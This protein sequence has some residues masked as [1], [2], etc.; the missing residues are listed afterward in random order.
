MNDHPLL[1][2]A[3]VVVTGVGAQWLAWRL[4]LP[5]LLLLLAAG[6]L[7]GPISGWMLEEPLLDPDAVLGDLLLPFVTLSVALILYEGGLTLR[8]AELKGAGAPTWRLV[9]MGMAVTWVLTAVA[10]HWLLN[11]AW[12]LAILFGAILVVT[13]PT[14]IIPLL[15]E[16]RPKGRVG[17]IAKWEGIIIDPIGA[18][19][20]VLVFEV[21]L[22]GDLNEAPL[23]VVL[24]IAKTVLLAGGLGVVAGFVLAALLRAF[25]I[26]EFLENPVSL[27]FVIAVSTGS[28]FIQSESG[29]FAATAMG[30]TLANQRLANV[31]SLVEFKENLRVL[32]ISSLFI[33][34]AARVPME[35]I[36]QIG[37]WTVPFLLLLIAAI[38]PVCVF[39]STVGSR[40]ARAERIFLMCLSPRGIVAAAV[41]S[42]FALRMQDEGF[43]QS[44][45]L[46]PITFSVIVGTVLFSSIIV[47]IIARRMGVADPNPQGVL[48]AGAHETARVLAQAINDHGY[49]VLLVDTNRQNIARA[50]MAGLET[51]VGSII[52]ERITDQLD[53]GGLGYLFAI[54]PNDWVN[55]LAVRRFARIF[56][57]GNV[58]QAAPTRHSKSASESHEHLQGRW[59]FGKDATVAALAA[60]IRHG[61]TIKATPITE[62]FGL[63][64]LHE[65]YSG[66]ALPLF[67]LHENK[68]LQV[69]DDEH[70]LNVRPGQT[71]I[72][73]VRPPE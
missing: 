9:T 72:S 42:I 48:I 34:L 67:L 60:R 18:M 29:L 63:D 52:G 8:F 47:P 31:H 21:I 1:A 36:G 38:R 49:R 33:L 16:I 64:E 3:A 66:R 71:L 2:L 12:P 27:M 30:I 70:E 44:Q 35:T 54:T 57:R 13:G 10:A 11:L 15:R 53:L 14:V 24:A 61:A 56:G 25:L 19:L 5:S 51:H 50:R 65:E 68:R 73:L 45:L 55:M 41:A 43:E 26:P 20:A 28:E 4:R 22:L 23:H 32:L 69:I 17:A 37:W 7:M 40:L 59:L 6:F 58:F 46:V 62:E 39:V